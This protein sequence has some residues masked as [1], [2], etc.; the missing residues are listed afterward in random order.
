MAAAAFVVP[1]GLRVEDHPHPALL[2]QS[3]EWSGYFRI[4]DLEHRMKQSDGSR[5]VRVSLDDAR[6]A[7]TGIFWSDALH[8]AA[9]IPA[10]PVSVQVTGRLSSAGGNRVMRITDLHF[11]SSLDLE[12][13]QVLL[14]R[15]FVPTIALPSFES[16]LQCCSTLPLPLRQF[17]GAV[18]LDPKVTIGFLRCKGSQRHHHAYSGGLLVHSVEL[19]D[20]AR[21]IALRICP[22]DPGMADLAQVAVLFHD[23][24]KLRTVGEQDRPLGAFEKGSMEDPHPAIGLAWMEPELKR[25]E[26]V[27]P[28]AACTLRETWGYLANPGPRGIPKGPLPTI[29]QCVD[30]LSA[31]AKISARREVIVS[32][33]LV[34]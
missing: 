18:L 8:L 24:G 28:E 13:P 17:V 4:D 20:L 10:L 26:A 33:E 19:L 9:A 34:S 25:L 7:L 29:V 16:L 15:R 1:A 22:E 12:S 30:R 6:G 2:D 14:P 23:L 3:S 31:G 5:Y 32:S 27:L 11:V 21:M